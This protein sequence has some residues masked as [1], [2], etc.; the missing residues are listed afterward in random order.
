MTN[1]NLAGLRPQFPD[2]D[3]TLVVG[4]GGSTT[5]ATNLYYW[6]NGYSRGGMNLLTSLGQKSVSVGQK[7]TWTVTTKAAGDD[8]FAW[9]L[10][11][12]TT[13][14]ATQARVL[15]LARAKSEDQLTVDD[16][17]IAVQLTH[18]EHFSL[19]SI[20][21]SLPTTNL[22]DGMIRYQDNAYRQYNSQT[23][24]WEVVNGWDAYLSSTLASLSP[25]VYKGGC[26]VPILSNESIIPL[27]AYEGGTTPF[28][29]LSILNGLSEGSGVI[30]PTGTKLSLSARV[31][32]SDEIGGNY[33]S[34]R[35]E[36]VP[37]QKTRRSDGTVTALSGGTITWV[38][39]TPFYTLTADLERGYALEFDVRVVDALLPEGFNFTFF[40]SEYGTLSAPI[41]ANASGTL[42][43]G[44][45]GRLRLVPALTGAFRLSGS[46]V[47][48]VDGETVSYPIN[49]PGKQ[50]YSFGLQSDTADQVA[51]ISG[52]GNGSIEFKANVNALL[53]TEAVRGIVSTEAITAAPSSWVSVGSVSANQSISLT[54]N[55]PCDTDGL[56]TI[57]ADYPDVIANSTEGE[58][59]PD[60][61]RI[62]LR[63][64]GS[65]ITETSPVNVTP[66]ESQTLIITLVGSTATLPTDPGEDY[67]FWDY[68]TI[69]PSVSV[70]TSNL[71]AG[72]YEVAIAYDYLGDKI[73]KIS[74]SQTD[75]ALPE[76]ISTIADSSNLAAAYSDIY[77]QSG[78][79][80]AK[81]P[82]LQFKDGLS[83]VRSGDR[84]I[85]TPDSQ[86]HIRTTNPTTANDSSQGYVVGDKWLNTVAK[87]EYTLVSAA[88]GVADWQQMGGGGGSNSIVLSG[89]VNWY[90]ATDGDADADGLTISTPIT[91]EEAVSRI[92]RIDA[93]QGLILTLSFATGVYTG[94]YLLQ[95]PANTKNTF[96]VKFEGSEWVGISTYPTIEI[97]GVIKT[98][99]L[100]T[101]FK[102]IQL[103]YVDVKDANIELQDICVSEDGSLYLNG[104]QTYCYVWGLVK[105]KGASKYFLF[106]VQA[107][108]YLELDANYHSDGGT[109]NFT[110]GF[111]RLIDGGTLA[112]DSSPNITGTFTGNKVAY[113]DATVKI[114]YGEEFVVD[115]PGSVI[116]PYPAYLINSTNTLAT[117]A[118]L[119]AENITV[120]TANFSTNLSVADD[121]VQKALE[122]LDGLIAGG[123]VTPR[124]AWNSGTSYVQY[125]AV[126]YQGSAYI[127][128]TANTNKVPGVDVEW[129]LWVEKGET[130][131]TGATGSQ[132]IQ[133]EPGNDGADGIAATISVGTVTTGAAGS[134]V[135]VTNVGT[136]SAAIFDITIPRGDT[137]A[138]G[139]ATASSGLTLEHIST[140]SAPAA[141]N[142]I[143]YGKS[144]GKIYKRPASGSEEEIGAG[145]AGTISDSTF[146]IQDNTDAT[147]QIAFEASGITTGTTRTLTAPNSSGTIALT[148]DLF[149]LVST[150]TTTY[151]ANNKEEIPCNT[152]TTGTFTVTTPA[153]GEFAVFDIGGTTPTTGFGVNNLTITP[154][155]GTIMGTTSYVLDVGAVRRRFILVGTDWR[156][157]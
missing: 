28:L 139:T 26:D 120:D 145:F 111:V 59:N 19:G 72:T 67:N 136:S 10:S 49:A 48:D 87:Q 50:Q 124:G 65:T 91:L 118:S 84:L 29:R 46:G 20:V 30:L 47:I 117:T 38:Y 86:T 4:S 8:V 152:I 69:T 140:P 116:S 37:V 113:N 25:G 123:G 39:G 74:H 102:D 13:N 43:Y 122:T 130:G 132:G 149:T 44:T 6:V 68:G 17:P 147:K 55:Y 70:T 58:F 92:Q 106:S 88:I 97:T 33:L 126:E 85:V 57:R 24:A 115:L 56:G 119:I 133:G 131:S 31:N 15:C 112:L 110:Q 114:D 95:I 89:D 76:L 78:V 11:A 137:G 101:I 150:K 52:I 9:V 107:N 16:P 146:R 22:L 71:P 144:D 143:V 63:R 104:G 157:A 77:N 99:G 90:V 7:L 75:G 41:A 100:D 83:V 148:S 138:T 66:G 82:E 51:A 156:V 35:I 14:D 42:I 153:S 21:G 81:V 98:I 155:S 23:L 109:I 96:T 36:I 105:V 134:S 2:T 142:T 45:G 64:N 94:N 103:L 27:P 108:A 54:V 79:L 62:F 53:S 3:F 40:I 154:A 129:D 73:V 12:S 151:T 1:S 61:L 18:D 93:D 121:T 128:N 125:D 32:G 127:A 60:R 141:G 5:I 80:Q 34:G 135:A